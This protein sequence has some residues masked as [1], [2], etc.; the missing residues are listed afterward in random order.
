MTIFD[1]SVM[2]PYEQVSMSIAIGHDEYL[3]AAHL[4]YLLESLSLLQLLVDYHGDD[5]WFYF[6]ESSRRFRPRPDDIGDIHKTPRITQ[7]DAEFVV[8]LAVVAGLATV[9]SGV[10]AAVTTVVGVVADRR[11]RKR[12]AREAAERSVRDQGGS[13][14]AVQV[15]GQIGGDFIVNGNVTYITVNINE[16]RAA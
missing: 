13:V 11:E 10:A 5:N 1:P 14:V 8:T 3:E 4:S 6:D 9:V 2:D 16:D 7:I 15:A 12:H